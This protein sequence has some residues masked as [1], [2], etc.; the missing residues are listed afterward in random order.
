MFSIPIPADVSLRDKAP[1]IL[2]NATFLFAGFGVASFVLEIL[3]V[4]DIVKTIAA[5]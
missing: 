3:K 4:I 2:A 5:G 1:A